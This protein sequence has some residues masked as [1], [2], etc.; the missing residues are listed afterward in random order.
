MCATP[1]YHAIIANAS[2]Y[3]KSK[4]TEQKCYE[5]ICKFTSKTEIQ[6]TPRRT[7]SRHVIRVVRLFVASIVRSKRRRKLFPKQNK[8]QSPRLTN[9]CHI[10]RCW[11]EWTRQR[12]SERIKNEIVFIYK[13]WRNAWLIERQSTKV[14]NYAPNWAVGLIIAR[15]GNPKIKWKPVDSIPN[16][17]QDK[18]CILVDFFFA[19]FVA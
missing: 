6:S 1:A 5:N 19:L 2:R 4:A 9:L 17:M 7:F 8:I 13:N 11:H 18:H 16:Q 15:V 14:V 12:P 3:K 10:K